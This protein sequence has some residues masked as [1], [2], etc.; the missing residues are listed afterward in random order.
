MA[1]NAK[2]RALEAMKTDSGTG[3]GKKTFEKH[4]HEYRKGKCDC[5]KEK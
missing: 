4:V 2:S 3:K 1:N 5:G